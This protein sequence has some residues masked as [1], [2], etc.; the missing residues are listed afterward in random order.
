MPK[1]KFT[2]KATHPDYKPGTYSGTVEADSREQAERL[3]RDGAHK[4]RVDSFST[5]APEA[6]DIKLTEN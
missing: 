6:T 5:T 3:I 1:F 4:H 2:A